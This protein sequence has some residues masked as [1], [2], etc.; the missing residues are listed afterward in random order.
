MIKIIFLILV[1]FF[2]LS[3]QEYKIL[4]EESPPYNYYED[5]EI[6][7]MS[8][9]IVREILKRVGH[10]DD[11]RLVSWS[12]AY[13]AAKNYDDYAIFGTSRESHRENLFKWVGP[14]SNFE[15][16]LYARKDFA[17]EISTLEDAKNVTSIG[18]YK[19][20]AQEQKLQNLGFTNLSSTE[21]N[22]INP[23]RLAAGEIELWAVG[24]VSGIEKIRRSK[25][26]RNIFKIVLKYCES[27]LYIAFS[28]NVADTTIKE[29]QNA[30]DAMKSDGTY[31][32]IIDKYTNL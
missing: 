21:N 27:D 9:E 23:I 30:L 24:K 3:A 12:K 16:V 28:K 17:K 4:T 31:T 22:I 29:W 19:D 13:N 25:V 10:K 14:I 8:T 20:D 15:C 11:I 18:V 26:D 2:S 32:K 6:K 1:S 5:G 7:G